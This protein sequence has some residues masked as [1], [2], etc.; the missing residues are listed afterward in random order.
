MLDGDNKDMGACVVRNESLRTAFRRFNLIC[1]L[2]LAGY[3]V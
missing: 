3:S 1:V 2:P